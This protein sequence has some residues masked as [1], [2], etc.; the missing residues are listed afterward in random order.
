MG[1]ERFVFS[2]G[3][4]PRSVKTVQTKGQIHPKTSS[5]FLRGGEILHGVLRRAISSASSHTLNTS[6]DLY[7]N[8][9]GHYTS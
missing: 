7:L 9:R 6:D 3:V 2:R 8:V 1:I 4:N 5:K